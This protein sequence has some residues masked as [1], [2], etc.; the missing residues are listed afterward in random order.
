MLRKSI[1]RYLRPSLSLAIGAM[2]SSPPLSGPALASA[3]PLAAEPQPVD[4]LGRL[5]AIP[6]MRVKEQRTR[7]NELGYRRFQMHYT[8]PVDHKNPAAGTFEQTIQLYHK[9]DEQGPMIMNTR[10]Y[11]LRPFDYMLPLAHQLQG[12]SI[13]IEH[14]FFGTSTPASGDDRYLNIQQ[15]AADH[16][17]IA[18]ALKPIYQNPWISTG[19]SKGG[20]TAIYF[21]RFYPEDVDAT[22]AF[23]APNSFGRADLR[24]A[25]F[26]NQ[27]GTQACRAKLNEMQRRLLQNK[28]E[29]A[30]KME[31]RAQEEENSSF[32]R[33]PGGIHQ[34]FEYAVGESAFA[35]WQY[36]PVEE[37]ETIP[38]KEASDD[39]LF[40]FFWGLRT[41]SL[42]SDQDFDSY[43]SYYIQAVRQL[44]Y[45]ALDVGPYWWL[46][47]ENP[48]DY[49]PYLGS[50]EKGEFDQSAMVDIFLWNAFASKKMMLIYGENDPWTAGS[51][52]FFGTKGRDVHRFDVPKG[53]HGV[54]VFSLDP[55]TKQ[56]AVEVLERWSGSTFRPLSRRSE[57]SGYAPSSSLYPDIDF[58]V[59]AA[60]ERFFEPGASPATRGF[61]LK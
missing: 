24:Y 18:Q 49:A 55:E 25:L 26:M 2:L 56:R 53:T 14:R 51:F 60:D 44:G 34:A 45:P 50:A 41:W 20:M 54:Q 22:V 23:V 37:C 57:A 19:A 1:F 58:P 42:L 9:S 30:A 13:A 59:E 8:Q 48:N 32:H 6:G 7:Y 38:G 3:N 29:F 40:D 43:N 35:F 31:T 11:S 27:V 33:V 47:R 61:R 39:A 28:E 46:L 10:G 12:S 52:A 36:K 17:R 4:I 21:R 15:A 5:A 16:H